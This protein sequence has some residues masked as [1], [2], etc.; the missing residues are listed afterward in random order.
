MDSGWSGGRRS[1]GMGIGPVNADGPRAR[2]GG[3]CGAGRRSPPRAYFFFDFALPALLR[4][5]ASFSASARSVFSHEK[6]VAVFF[7][8]SAPV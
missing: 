7:L 3:C 6:A 4:P 8:P 5:A 1:V 2:A